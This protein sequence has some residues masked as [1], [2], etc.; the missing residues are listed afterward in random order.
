MNNFDLTDKF[1]N[2]VGSVIEFL[3]NILAALVIL[4]IGGIVA[5]ILGSLT[6]KALQK[7]RFDRAL[8]SS[9]VGKYLSRIVD[10]PARFSGKV[11]FWLIMVGA[12]SLAIGALNLTV[13]NDLLAAVYGYVPHIIASLII[14]LVASAVSAGA[15]AFIQRVMGRTPIARLASTVVPA[16]AMSLAVFMILSEL[17]IATDIVNI[18]F[19]AMVGSV[20]LGL[21]LS[22]GLG[23]RE[24]AREL[25][26][27]A[28]ESVRSDKDDIKAG[29]NKA[30]NKVK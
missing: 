26:E 22:F 7:V 5:A 15:A 17:G 24:V 9:S 4:I 2:V 19:T 30:A 12:I 16:I 13:L 27:Q 11:V 25:L 28:A 29:V 14:F 10:S 3:P 6:R 21:A 8:H 23:G 18:L 20:A 1:E